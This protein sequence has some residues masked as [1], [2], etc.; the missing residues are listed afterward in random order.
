MSPRIHRLFIDLENRSQ[1]A[2]RFR[3][4]VTMGQTPYLAP[5]FGV[6]AISVLCVNQAFSM[7]TREKSGIEVLF[8]RGESWKASLFPLYE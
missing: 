2:R 4:K 8:G 5:I 6:D 1:T 7:L 3:T